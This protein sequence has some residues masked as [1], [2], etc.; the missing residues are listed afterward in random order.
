MLLKFQHFKFSCFVSCCTTHV[1]IASIDPH[2]FRQNVSSLIIQYNCLNMCHIKK[3]NQKFHYSHLSSL[4]HS[5]N[6]PSWR[7]RWCVEKKEEKISLQDDIIA[8]GSLN[9]E[10]CNI[11]FR[12][13][14]F[15][16]KNQIHFLKQLQMRARNGA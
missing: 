6:C 9:V 16:E 11:D 2:Y 14:M 5:D 8:L 12:L 15:K 1:F 7:R 3:Y 4:M 10:Y 13:V